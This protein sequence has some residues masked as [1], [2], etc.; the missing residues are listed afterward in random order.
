M[1]KKYSLQGRVVQLLLQAGWEFSGRV[2][3]SDETKIVLVSSKGS[4]VVY[5]QHIVAAMILDETISQDLIEDEKPRGYDIGMP[6]VTDGTKV[7]LNISEKQE[8]HYGSIIPADMLIGEDT[9][10]QVDFSVSFGDLKNARPGENKYGSTE[11]IR[12]FGEKD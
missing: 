7:D 11:E 2:E 9:G 10:P 3:Y 1:S 5:K 6:V 4:M 12:P 8:S